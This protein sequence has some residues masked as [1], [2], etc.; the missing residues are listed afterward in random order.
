M[1]DPITTGGASAS[2]V[3]A[4]AGGST[5]ASG[6]FNKAIADLEA[7]FE[8]AQVNSARLRKVGID[9]GSI[10]AADKKQATPV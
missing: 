8:T 7:S 1:A 10:L 2:D 3:N 9:E 6:G 5:D 4:A